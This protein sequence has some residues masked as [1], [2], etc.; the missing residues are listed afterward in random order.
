M[1]SAE[2]T[3]PPGSCIGRTGAGACNGDACVLGLGYLTSSGSETHSERQPGMAHFYTFLPERIRASCEAGAWIAAPHRPRR[4]V[5]LRSIYGVA[6]CAASRLSPWCRSAWLPLLVT[7]S[8]EPRRRRVRVDTLR[9]LR[10]LG[11]PQQAAWGYQK[12]IPMP[13][14]QNLSEI[15]I[16]QRK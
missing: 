13:C 1:I 14:L 2:S 11:R 15:F 10:G 7:R 5:S 4:S 6:P 8:V 12:D 9:P 3:A 16:D